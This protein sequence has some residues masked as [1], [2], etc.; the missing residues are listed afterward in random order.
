MLPIFAELNFVVRVLRI[1]LK[2][3]ASLENRFV[4]IN[5]ISLC[6]NVKLIVS[7]FNI[8]LAYV[9][10]L[11]PRLKT[12]SLILNFITSH[13]SWLV[14]KQ[15]QILAVNFFCKLLRNEHT[16]IVQRNYF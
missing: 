13:G 16:C 6:A 10:T 9:A 1:D 3:V 8:K 7:A 2:T 4:L 15:Q 5:D 12:L 11:I 14:N